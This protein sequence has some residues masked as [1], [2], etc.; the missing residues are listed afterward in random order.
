MNAP[1]RD[2]LL[3]SSVN[4]GGVFLIGANG[5]ERWSK[6][7]TTGIAPIPGG[8]LL[9]RQ[10]EGSAE[11]RRLREREVHRFTLVERS[12][13]LHDLY[14]EED[15]L[16]VVATRINT[17][18][19]FDHAFKE[20]RHWS[21]PG[22]EDAQH[23]NSACVHDGRLLAS[24]FGRFQSHRGYKGRTSG[25]GEVFDLDSGEMRFGGLSQP[26]SLLSH[27]GRLWLCDS[28]ARRVC[29]FRGADREV[30]QGFDGYTRGLAIGASEVYVGLSRSR[31]A[32]H[33]DIASACIVVLDKARMVE[34]DRIPLPADEIYDIRII[35]PA[36][37]D[38]LR[39]AAFA[40]AVAE[41]DTQV[42]QRNRVLLAAAGAN[43]ALHH[44]NVRIAA[45]EAEAATN[46]AH[47]AM[48]QVRTDRM[49]AQLEEE[50]E[51]GSALDAEVDRL[52]AIAHR[53]AGAIRVRDEALAAA[54]EAIAVAT[55]AIRDR[56]DALAALASE[57][58]ELRAVNAAQAQVVE[59]Q[60]AS[61]EAHA[62]LVSL[63]FG[64]RIWRWTRILRRG[65]PA[66]PEVWIPAPP[67][68]VPVPAIPGMRDFDPREALQWIPP[69]VEGWVVGAR[70][71]RADVPIRGLAFEA[72]AEPLVSIL[73]TSYG[74]FART[75]ACL[76]SIRHAGDATPV[77]V[78]LVED[79][80]GEIEMERFAHVPGLRYQRNA[81]NL[82]FLRSVNAALPLVRGEFLHLLNNDTRV[83]P[84]WL[85]ALM[86]TF[87]LFHDC[88]IAGSKLVYPDGRLQEAGGIVW[89]D[90]GACN[91]GRGGH[92]DDP[93]ASVVREVDYA[94]GAS[95]LLRSG[96]MRELGGFDERYLP[97]YY[98]DTDLAFRLRLRGLK[99]YFQPASLVVHDEGASHGTDPDSGV[100]ASQSRNREVFRARWTDELERAQCPPGRHLFLARNRAQLKK[101]VLV[102]DR[103][104][105]HTDRDAGSRAV[106]H[107]LRLL[108]IKGFD[109]RF[110][111]QA[112]ERDVRYRA[113]LA[114]H[115]IEMF[116][117]AVTGGGFERWAEEYGRYLDYA[118]LSR[119]EIAQ[120]LIPLLRRHSAAEILFYGHD[121]HHLRLQRQSA[122]G[123]L[124]DGE[125]AVEAMA[126]VEHSVWRESDVVL[127]PSAEETSY[128]QEWL[129]VEGGRAKALTVPLFAVDRVVPL[130]HD[131]NA[132]RQGRR[133]LLFVGG[134]AHAPNADG[135]AWF[136]REVWPLVLARR[137]ATEC[138]LVG[139]DPPSWIQALAQED[140]RITAPG[141]VSE[142]VLH[143]E[144]GRALVAIAPLRFGAGTKGKVVEALQ[145][146]VPVVTTSTGAQGLSEAGFLRLA[147]A[148]GD[149][150]RHV[151]ELLDD[152]GRWLDAA[153]NGQQFV[154]EHYSP[155][156]LWHVL[157]M[158]MD[159]V[160]YPDVAARERSLAPRADESGPGGM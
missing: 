97:A 148:A 92:P 116:E 3:V 155:E 35:D 59:A 85:D 28:E 145:H 24:R 90:A 77:E 132:A 81:D 22:E 13:D 123:Q 15:R 47:Q 48:S 131:A 62:A 149:F 110:W 60:H 125:R 138:V 33:G 158:C 153:R 137:P 70:P 27:E 109:V 102:A 150:A 23:V 46:A 49:A 42:D 64:S 5:I 25:A 7:D 91:I 119:P 98:E 61:I 147:D 146:G 51:W 151:L 154:R 36:L 134:F 4:G 101:T 34:I 69:A 118:V 99:T 6:V 94:S 83:T 18:F 20:R 39:L 130:G 43:E 53:Q 40:D 160:P 1:L 157:S 73:V 96:L 50:M 17:V 152:P 108:Q 10:A 45:L 143:A 112:T 135:I 26:H 63:V 76:E 80:S 32:E 67:A 88:G 52:R 84:G 141:H 75:R 38:N 2:T 128:V 37:V 124:P 79:A 55:G 9:A 82:G 114:V 89:S 139:S 41:Y 100:K 115:G 126:R 68:E 129:R 156:S 144:Y 136:M 19:E 44:A 140:S 29:A 56:D 54:S 107:L 93:V 16:L 106:W 122:L 95:I 120:F 14:A 66:L 159:P 30:E 31:N 12:L 103:H 117:P 133:T 104:P 58:D 86:Q 57:R 121:I 74:D 127:Y 142:E 113:L 71:T 87:A 111:S 11:I 21:M 8:V 105:P 78:I 72:Q 65:E